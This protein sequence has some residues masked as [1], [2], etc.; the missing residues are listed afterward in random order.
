MSKRVFCVV[1]SNAMR[2]SFQS[3]DGPS[4]RGKQQVSR[5]GPTPRAP[6]DALRPH[7]YN[8]YVGDEDDGFVVCFTEDVGIVVIG[9]VSLSNFL[10]H[11]NEVSRHDFASPPDIEM[12]D[13]FVTLWHTDEKG[14]SLIERNCQHFSKAFVSTF[15]EQEVVTQTDNLNV[16]FTA[17]LGLSLFF[18]II[19][20]VSIFLNKNK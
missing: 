1:G 14:Y 2:F 10:R 6:L 16:V 3:S 4:E 17:S 19:A 8:V 20:G 13:K 18:G 9:E 11:H 15:C 5:V 7:H 12:V